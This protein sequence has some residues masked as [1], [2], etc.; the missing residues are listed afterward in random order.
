MPGDPLIGGLLLQLVLLILNAFFAMSEI[1][2]ISISES[3]AKHLAE[4]GTRGAQ[5][6]QK[7]TSVPARFLATIQ[8]GITLA[9]MLGSAFAAENLSGRLAVWAYDLFN[10]SIK[11]STL[12][13]ISLVGITLVLS[14]LTLVFGEL[15]PKRIAMQ[16][17]EKIALG[18]AGTISMFST[19]MRPFVAVLTAS[20]NGVLRLLGIDPNASDENV[21]EDEIRMMVDLGQES[22][23]I[24]EEE[25]DM[26]ENVFELNN[27]TAGEVMTHRTDIYA[28]N[29]DDTHEQIMEVLRES[30]Y[31][32]LPVYG[33][34]ADDVVGILRARD[35]FMNMMSEEKR[36][37]AE[38]LMPVQYVPE[39]IRTDV[40]L[41]NM[42]HLKVHIAI[43]LD[44][45]GGTAGLITMEDLL[46]EIVGNIYDESD[47]PD[48]DVAP[49]GENAFRVR[50]SVPLAHI[51]ELFDLD[52][53]DEDVDSLGGLV[54]KCLGAIP[55]E[56]SQPRVVWNHLNIQVEKIE[57]RRVEW[58]IVSRVNE[59]GEKAGGGDAELVDPKN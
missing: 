21:T 38:I 29:L 7:L 42:Q 56:G 43:V 2:V 15:V 25:R 45:Y 28:I 35:Y 10:Q 3:K 51:G 44:E 49:L 5:H 14:F 26:I 37:L 16:K 31:S 41:R 55:E 39:S 59:L 17:S 47:V 50:G 13:S 27:K 6:L 48:D 53:K 20:T 54:Y 4:E 18:I 22:G 52:L 58:A 33:K 9:N 32:R 46:E 19:L 1:A 12:N 24:E 8:I 40:L 34:D 30:G 11:Q 36:E 23:A 57:D